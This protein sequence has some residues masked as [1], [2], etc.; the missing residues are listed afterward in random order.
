VVR[1][2]SAFTLIELIFAIVVISIAVISLPTMNAVLSKGIEGNLVQEAIFASSAKINE[3]ISY[4]WDEN[5]IPS[6]SIYSQVIWSSANDC[7]QT[8]KLRTGH[9]Y[10][11][12]HRR[13]LDDNFSIVQ[14]TSSTAL[15]FEAN[16]AGI[17]DDID[18]FNNVSTKIF[19]DYQDSS[20][21]TSAEGYKTPYR[22]DVNVTY[23]DFGTTTASSKNIKKIDIS[24]INLTTHTIAT[25]IHTYSANIGEVDFYKRTY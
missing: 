15:G 1:K 4:P 18:D 5:S 13:C 10:Q 23:A 24:I 8:T 20:I 17:Y 3:I 21:I 6:N 19:I 25:K 11:Q 22:M 14:P 7:N 16:D 9:I 2:K 12:L